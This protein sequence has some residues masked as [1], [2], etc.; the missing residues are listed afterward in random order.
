LPRQATL[1]LDRKAS[2]SPRVKA[3][4]VLLV[5][6]LVEYIG[7]SVLRCGCGYL[8]AEGLPLTI[9]AAGVALH[10]QIRAPFKNSV[11]RFFLAI[12]T[13]VVCF[14]LVENLFYVLWFGHDAL[15]EEWQVDT[16]LQVAR[17]L[18]IGGAALLVISLVCSALLLDRMERGSKRSEE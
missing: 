18:R 5:L 4:G 12:L 14:V 17:I 6:L 7:S 10:T 11:T 3:V 15:F 2:D 8:H 13:G 1:G 16:R 9:P